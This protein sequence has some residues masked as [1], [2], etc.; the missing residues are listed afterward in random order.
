MYACFKVIY[1]ASH[2][3]VCSCSWIL[4][5]SKSCLW[6]VYRHKRVTFRHCKLMTLYDIPLNW[7][8]NTHLI[9]GYV[10]NIKLMDQKFTHKVPCR[11]LAGWIW[12]SSSS[13]E[14][15]NDVFLIPCAR[16]LLSR[17]PVYSNETCIFKALVGPPPGGR[18]CRLCSRLCSVLLHC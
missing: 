13:C 8:T 4:F 3:A 18:Y 9:H 15:Q 6:I 16:A 1:R 2:V 12:K 5:V 14:W 17:L 11:R 7:R 10:F